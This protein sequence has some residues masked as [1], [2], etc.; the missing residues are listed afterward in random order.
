LLG[1]C[2]V[3]DLARASAAEIESRLRAEGYTVTRSEIAGWIAQAQEF[4]T[5]LPSHQAVESP[6]AT[7]EDSP[8]FSSQEDESSQTVIESPEDFAQESP[9]L[10]TEERESCH[11]TGESVPI[12][13][14]GNLPSSAQDGIWK[15]FASFSIAL[16]NKQ[17]EGRAEQRTIVR[18]LEAGTVRIWS[19]IESDSLH[20]SFA[21]QLQQWIQ[22]QIS[23]SKPPEPEAEKSHVTTC[24]IA[25]II[26][27]GLFQPPQTG[28]P[29][30]V[31]R[32]GQGFSSFV[33]SGESFA[34]AITFQLTGLKAADITKQEIRYSAQV[35]ARHRTTGAIA[36]LGNT[37]ATILV[38][39][40]PF[41]TALLPETTLQQPGMYRLQVLVTFQG[42]TI[43]PAFFDV[44]ML[45]VI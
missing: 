33:Q 42:A 22:S 17:V 12:E 4:V 13:V 7:V 19:G 36:S 44:P 41:Y 9:F 29:A 43:P 32:A 28:M 35:Y 26:Q 45:Q 37:E 27:L 16:Q 10:S 2:D 23:E 31:D 21:P 14:E 1:I 15:T 6:D 40:R 3:R 38:Q 8:H 25:R 11:P 30:L 20:D 5:D 34:L 18:H 39:E 24:A